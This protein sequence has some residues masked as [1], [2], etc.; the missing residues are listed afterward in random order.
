MLNV[1]RYMLFGYS[2]SVGCCQ[3]QY[4]GI[5]CALLFQRSLALSPQHLTPLL[6]VQMVRITLPFPEL[7][8][9]LY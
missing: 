9:D 7:N 3:S 8:L 2:M 5:T 4:L 1:N 6:P